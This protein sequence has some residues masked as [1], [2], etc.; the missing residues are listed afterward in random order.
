[1]SEHD[2]PRNLSRTVWTMAALGALAIHAGGIALAV[3]SIQPESA[4]DLGAPAMAEG[5]GR[6]FR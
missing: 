4:T 1:M 5:I 3:T 2:Q 6:P